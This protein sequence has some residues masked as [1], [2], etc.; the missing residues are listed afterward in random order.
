VSLERRRA[1]AH[2]VKINVPDSNHSHEHGQIVPEWNVLQV[3]VYAM[4]A[5]EELFEV[6]VSD[7]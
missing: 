3:F 6:V 1:G 4:G 2:T 5:L 7:K